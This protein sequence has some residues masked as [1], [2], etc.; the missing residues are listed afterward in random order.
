MVGVDAHHGP[1]RPAAAAAAA[2]CRLDRRRTRPPARRLPPHGAAR[3]RWPPA[4]GLRD[5][6]G[7]STKR[8]AEPRGTLARTPL[9]SVLAWGCGRHAPRISRADR[10]GGP[11]VTRD[12]FVPR[13]SDLVTGVCPE[14]RPTSAVPAGSAPAD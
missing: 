2:T 14:A 4:G 11:A 1:A 9:W 6:H 12:T 3:P 10:I 13:P 5:R 8:P 7:G